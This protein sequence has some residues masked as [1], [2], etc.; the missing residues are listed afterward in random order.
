[1]RIQRIIRV[2]GRIMFYALL[3]LLLIVVIYTLSHDKY[4]EGLISG[5]VFL[6][7]LDKG[8]MCIKIPA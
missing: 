1:M 2:V 7:V 6:L 8:L 4:L 3:F 5:V